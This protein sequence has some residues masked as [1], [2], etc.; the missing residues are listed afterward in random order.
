MSDP[1]PP[2]T[3]VLVE[4]AKQ[5]DEAAKNE[6]F[7]R[8]APR[9]LP[10]VRARLRGNDLRRVL[11]S[12]DIV[13]DVMLQAYRNLDRFAMHDDNSFLHFLGVSAAHKI[14]DYADKMAA[15]KRSLK[16][17]VSL[18]EPAAG[19][20]GPIDLP[21]GTAATPST[22]VHGHQL[23]EALTECLH[24]LSEA[25]RELIMMRDYAGMD[26]Q[27]IGEVL[28]ID[29]DAARQ[30]HATAK[31]ALAKLLRKCGIEPDTI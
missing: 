5:G 17:Q 21:D 12:Q 30:R 25:R 1:L 11:E 13:Q 23:G 7:A 16:R 28:G 29:A 10:I 15:D 26:W 4:L 19:S 27:S 8:Y 31:V 22:H 3:V 2:R 6:L 18:D 14:C 24:E 9:L 20:S